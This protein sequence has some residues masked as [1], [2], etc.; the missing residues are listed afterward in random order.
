VNNIIFVAHNEKDFN[1]WS[2][3]DFFKMK[4]KII[5]EIEK[6]SFGDGWIVGYLIQEEHKGDFY[7]TIKF[8]KDNKV[9]IYHLKEERVFR[10]LDL[11]YKFIE[12]PKKFL[13]HYFP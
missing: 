6:G 1:Y 5:R 3:N 2:K 11:V 4:W 8:Q 7:R 9:N 10:K 12:N 13:S